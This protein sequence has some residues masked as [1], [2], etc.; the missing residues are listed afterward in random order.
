MNIAKVCYYKML[1]KLLTNLKALLFLKAFYFFFVC[2]YM[3]SNKDNIWS[4]KKGLR[5]SDRDN[6]LIDWLR[7]S[8][9]YLIVRR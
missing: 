1:Y 3:Y 8:L 6:L 9:Q 7:P 5:I 2:T 4:C